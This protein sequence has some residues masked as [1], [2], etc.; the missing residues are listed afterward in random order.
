MKN[1]DSQ[2]N[3]L[4]ERRVKSKPKYS[5]NLSQECIDVILGNVSRHSP[6]ENFVPDELPPDEL[7]PSPV[8]VQHTFIDQSSFMPQLVNSDGEIMK[9]DPMHCNDVVTCESEQ[10]VDDLSVVTSSYPISTV[11]IIM[12]SVTEGNDIPISSTAHGSNV[13][14]E[15]PMSTDGEQSENE[16]SVDIVPVT[17]DVVQSPQNL[18]SASENS[19]VP[20]EG[21]M[22]PG[23]NE[24]PE[25]EV[26]SQEKPQ[27]ADE[28][29]DY[30]CDNSVVPSSGLASDALDSNMD[31]VV[32]TS[33][34]LGEGSETNV[35]EQTVDSETE[36]PQ[37]Q[38]DIN[39]EAHIGTEPNI[40][41]DSI[42]KGNAEPVPNEVQ[43]NEQQTIENP[44]STEVGDNEEQTSDQNNEDS[45]SGVD[46]EV[47]KGKSVP[48][49]DDTDQNGTS[50]DSNAEDSA[51]DIDLEPDNRYCSCGTSC[52]CSSSSSSSSSNEDQPPKRGKRK[53]SDA[54]TSKSTDSD[55]PKRKLR[56]YVSGRKPNYKVDTSDNDTDSDTNKDP[57]Y[58][59][60]DS[61]PDKTESYTSEE[62]IVVTKTQKT[63]KKIINTK[64]GQIEIKHFKLKSKKNRKRTY[65][66]K[67][68]GKISKTQKD[69]NSHVKKDHKDCKFICFHSDRTFDSDNALYKHERSHYNLPYGCSNCDRRFQ[70]PYQVKA[71]MKVHTQKN[72]YK[73]LHCERSFTTN[74][75]MMT[76]AKTHFENSHVL[77]KNVQPLTKFTTLKAT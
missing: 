68:C 70:F 54:E 12:P 50:S 65:K 47:Q 72:L 28:T 36:M 17:G 6:E 51:V 18:G 16:N 76:H 71:H 75:S 13:K 42:N 58:S 67:Y 66:C 64:S 74:L 45:A 41:D 61:D 34:E 49:A 46:F 8:G 25:S 9:F 24:I 30:T 11:E 5:M 14:E 20:H 52:S 7:P 3:T 62:E 32:D 39:E 63:K 53:Y 33:T 77:T 10:S 27:N 2:T 19:E 35:P 22:A 23:S 69:H 29:V 38:L 56:R 40:P 26:I 4:S 21:S 15:S 73:C 44:V 1:N 60:K 59:G 48:P 31:K 55:V 57:N 43:D 37:N